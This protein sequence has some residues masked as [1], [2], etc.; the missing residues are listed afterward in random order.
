MQ[1]VRRHEAQLENRSIPLGDSCGIWHWQVCFITHIKS[2]TLGISAAMEGDGQ[3]GLGVMSLA[4]GALVSAL[5]LASCV[6]AG[7]VPVLRVHSGV[8][9]C[10][11][12]RHTRAP[13]V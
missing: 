4:P 9:S 10:E 12:L 2:Y 5:L 3:L 8:D 6:T 11:W 7:E 13:Q 1:N